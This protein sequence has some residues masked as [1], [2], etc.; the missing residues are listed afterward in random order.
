MFKKLEQV[1]NKFIEKLEE[2]WEGHKEEIAEEIEKKLG[3]V[4]PIKLYAQIDEIYDIFE[5]LWHIS[6]YWHEDDFELD[7]HHCTGFYGRFKNLD[8][9]IEVTRLLGIQQNGSDSHPCTY[10]VQFCEGNDTCTFW[11][12]VGRG[13]IENIEIF[14]Q[15][16]NAITIIKTFDEI[17]G[18]LKPYKEQVIQ[19]RNEERLEQQYN[20]KQAR[21][22][23]NII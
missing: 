19:N 6:T 23:E 15:K 13:T 16:Y 10:H 20:N 14:N 4:K 9:R 18:F 8:M 12:E 1:R 17:I 2:F 21:E 22:L 3:F 11:V 7:Y 5:G